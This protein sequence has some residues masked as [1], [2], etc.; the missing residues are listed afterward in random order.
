VVN[1]ESVL[2]S[3][4]GVYYANTRDVYFQK[5]VKL[6]DPEYTVSTDTLLYNVNSEI[7]RFV[8]PTKIFD[9]KSSI[10]TRSGYYDLKQ[11]LADFNKRPVIRDSSQTVIADSINYNKNSGAG[12]AIGQVD[13]SDTSQGISMVAG[14]AEFNNTTKVIKTYQRPLMKFLQEGDS[15]F[16]AADTLYSAY[17]G[18]DST[19][20]TNPADTFRFFRAYHHVKIFSDSLQGKCDSLYYSSMDSVFRFFK[21]PVM[22]AQESQISGDTIY[23]FTKNRKADKVQ[24]NENAFSV[25]KS[26]EGLYNQLRGNS[27]SGQF[28]NGEIDFLRSK[29]NSESLYYLQEE[30]SS[31]MGMNY[32]QADAIV[33]KFIGKEIKRVSWINGVTGTTYPMKQIPSD[34]KE[35]RN[36]KW[37]DA[38]RP[39]SIGDLLSIQ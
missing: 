7:A 27:M 37:L 12:M 4:E 38:I 5:N 39:K 8:S 3:K 19:G 21:E 23:L 16:V 13:Y 10:E 11:G 35:L 15:L 25:N 20:Q 34:K 32:S 6:V 33:M 24:I 14:K 1:G 2:T 29:G 30:D 9:G 26:A 31:Y 36:F 22:W 18:F 17:L 28:I